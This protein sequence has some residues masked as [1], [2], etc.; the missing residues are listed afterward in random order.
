MSAF[1]GK[2]KLKP[3]KVK[4]KS[5]KYINKFFEIKDDPYILDEQLEILQIFICDVYGHKG[6]RIKPTQI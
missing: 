3:L 4:L 5:Q 6:D 2:G 1:C